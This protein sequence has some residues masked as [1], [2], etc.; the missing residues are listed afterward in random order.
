MVL[1]KKNSKLKNIYKYFLLYS[2][3]WEKILA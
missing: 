1:Q 2:E 3:E